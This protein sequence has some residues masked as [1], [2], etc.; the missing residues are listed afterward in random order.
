MNEKG[1]KIR[2]HLI[3][4]SGVQGTYSNFI[5]DTD[6]LYSQLIFDDMTSSG[7]NILGR[8]EF[9]SILF[10]DIAFTIYTAEYS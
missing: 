5:P 6:T 7:E 10:I 3:I 1:K 2:N 9:I 8:R 4:S